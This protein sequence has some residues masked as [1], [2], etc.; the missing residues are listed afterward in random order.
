MMGI[1]SWHEGL[2]VCAVGK[3]PRSMTGLLGRGSHPEMAKPWLTPGTT[4]CSLASESW[5]VR[6][7]GGAGEGQGSRKEPRSW[8]WPGKERTNAP[9]PFPNPNEFPYHHRHV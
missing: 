4:F 2:G 7:A 8:T 6:A 3:A 9:R 1:S 5:E